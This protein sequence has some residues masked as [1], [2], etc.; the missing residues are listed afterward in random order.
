MDGWG[1]DVR[2]KE[3]MARGRGTGGLWPCGLAAPILAVESLSTV[4]AERGNKI[5]V[6]C[7]HLHVTGQLPCGISLYLSI[8]RFSTDYPTV[9]PI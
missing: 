2:R 5:S 4:V 8:Y 6:I 7:A 3:E 9:S 1:M